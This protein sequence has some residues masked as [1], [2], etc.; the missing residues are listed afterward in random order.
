[1]L[2]SSI[3][4]LD[5]NKLEFCNILKVYPQIGL[6]G[7]WTGTKKLKTEEWQQSCSSH[8]SLRWWDMEW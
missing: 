4:I 8:H 7:K 2:D 6:Q 5:L 1:M 3:L